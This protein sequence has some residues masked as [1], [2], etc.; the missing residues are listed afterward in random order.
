MIREHLTVCCDK[1]VAALP[2]PEDPT[3][4]NKL[5][6]RVSRRQKYP[7]FFGSHSEVSRTVRAAGWYDDSLQTLCPKHYK[8]LLHATQIRSTSDSED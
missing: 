5:A 7:T 6:Y 8:E 4:L 1:C 2:D 3:A